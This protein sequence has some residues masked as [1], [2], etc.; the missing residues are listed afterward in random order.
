MLHLVRLDGRRHDR[1]GFDCGVSA[2]N[3]YLRSQAAQHHRSGIATTHVLCDDSAPAR[4]LGF[5]SLAAA[6]VQLG[7]LSPADQQRLPRYPIP[8]A[9]LARLAVALSEQRRGL[10]AALLQDAVKRCLDLRTQ[11]GVRLLVVDAKDPEAAGFYASFGFR[12]TA[13]RALTLYLSLG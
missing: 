12:P 5:Y 6:Q 11:I 10:G 3:H 8:A 7:D 9:R 2:L 1:N 13:E 4:I